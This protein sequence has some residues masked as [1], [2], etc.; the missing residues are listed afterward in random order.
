MDFD[1]SP[2]EAAFRAEAFEWLSAHARLRDADE[3][4]YALTHMSRE[5]ELAYQRRCK[6]WQRTLF[7]G[8]WAG[9]TWPVVPLVKRM[10]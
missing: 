4:V 10:R 9:I 2:E 5:A 3:P 6:D 8:G 7:E 1:D